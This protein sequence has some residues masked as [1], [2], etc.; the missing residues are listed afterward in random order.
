MGKAT[1]KG[2]LAHKFR[3][4]ATALAIVLGVSFVAGTYRAHRHHHG[5]LRRPVQA[6]HPGCR[7]RRPLRGDLRRLRHRRG[8]RPHAGLPARQDQGGRRR[9]G[10]RGQRHRLRPARRQGRQ[11][12][13]H[14]RRPKP[15]C[16]VQQGRPVHGRL[17]RPLGAAADRADRDGDRRQD[18]R[19][20]RLQGRRPGQGAVPGPGPHLHHQ[21]HHRLRRRRQP[22]RGPPGRLRPGHRPGGDEPRGPLRRDRRRRPGGRHPRAA[23]RPHPGRRR[24]EVRGPHR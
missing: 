19:G 9:P 8:P 4:A 22:R 17:D 7:R 21:R 16:V 15:W 1:L 12:G 5:Q 24:P 2:L 23:A 18:G 13:D 6:G 3:L 11:G 14:R 20:H 10:G